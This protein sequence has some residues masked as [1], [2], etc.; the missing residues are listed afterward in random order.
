MQLADN[1]TL[2]R[3]DLGI[4]GAAP[5]AKQTMV[6]P[7]CTSEKP[8]GCP[9]SD[10]EHCVCMQ[11]CNVSA[12]PQSPDCQSA[13]EAVRSPDASIDFTLCTP[14]EGLQLA[15]VALSGD[16]CGTCGS[17]SPSPSGDIHQLLASQSEHGVHCTHPST[18]LNWPPL[19]QVVTYYAAIDLLDRHWV[20]MKKKWLR[21]YFKL[22][23]LTEVLFQGIRFMDYACTVRHCAYGIGRSLTVTLVQRC[24]VL[25]AIIHCIGLTRA[26]IVSSDHRNLRILYG[27]PL[28]KYIS[29]RGEG[30]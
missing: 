3:E 17:L 21:H 25:G 14:I 15:T 13:T 6:L 27:Q 2:P 9:S 11:D 10:C 1:S 7:C 24:P 28:R 22:L 19:Q 4:L 23:C 18:F 26:D 29:S 20:Q 8:P 30:Q 12:L 16:I 5:K